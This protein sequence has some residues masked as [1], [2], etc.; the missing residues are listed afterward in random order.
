MTGFSPAGQH[1]QVSMPIGTSQ[2][3]TFLLARYPTKGSDQ[4]EICNTGL[5]IHHCIG[6]RAV[7]I[8]RAIE[9]ELLTLTTEYPVVTLLGPRQAGKTTLA[10]AALPD[11]VYSNLE[12]PEVRDLALADPKAYLAGLP[13]RAIIDEI[14]RAP[15]L[16]SP[17][18]T[19]SA[20][21]TGTKSTWSHRPVG[22][23]SRRRSSPPPPSPPVCSRASGA[24]DAL[25]HN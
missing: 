24:S 15:V 6:Y 22:R 5:V 23:C 7:M 17:T 16:L 4:A 11:H 14:Q 2:C 21:A 13:S 19:S 18:C 10:R 3:F 1:Q 20:T 25:R 12:I 9:K 8:P